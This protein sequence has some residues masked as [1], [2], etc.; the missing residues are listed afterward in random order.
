MAVAVEVVASSVGEPVALEAAGWLVRDGPPQQ[1]GIQQR[2]YMT[3]EGT[4]LIDD[5]EY[6]HQLR[7]SPWDRCQDIAVGSKGD[8]CA[9]I[10]A[11]TR[12]GM[13]GWSHT[14]VEP[15]PPTGLSANTHLTGFQFFR[16]L[17]YCMWHERYDHNDAL[18]DPAS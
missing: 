2:L 15:A 18:D 1:P 13:L 11:R 14:Q 17:G 4:G 9:G 12:D 5:A 7:P 8:S 10:L 3:V 6:L 16:F